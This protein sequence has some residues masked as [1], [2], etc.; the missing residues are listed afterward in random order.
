[1]GQFQD[2]FQAMSLGEK[3]ILP[4]GVLL[5]IIGFFPWYRIDL[6]VTTVS[7]NGWESPGAIW[8]ILAILVG[9]VMA[10]AVAVKNFAAA[11]TLPDN[12]SGITWPRIHLGLGIAALVFVIIKL[13]NESSHLGIG[14]YLGIIAAAALAAG[15]FLMF[16][17]EQAGTTTGAGGGGAPGGGPSGGGGPTGGGEGG[18]P[19]QS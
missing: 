16:R 18:G 4:A 13:L 8:S 17:D 12:I 19:P 5:F 15:G 2:K 6:V 14:F 11:G 3:I 9:L 1:M 7:R 10:A